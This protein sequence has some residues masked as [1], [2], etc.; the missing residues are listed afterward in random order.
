MGK[1]YSANGYISAILRRS[2]K[3]VLVEGV[4]D[5]AVFHRLMVESHSDFDG[6]NHVDHAGIFDDETMAGLGNKAK[7]AKLL[8]SIN[9]LI[10]HHPRLGEVF[11]SLTDREWDD[12]DISPAGMNGQWA[13]PA[14]PIPHFIT[15]GHSIENYFLD[16][17]AVIAYLK[18]MFSENLTPAYTA[19]IRGSFGAINS[20]A[21]SYSL[22]AKNK[23]CITRCDGLLD[24]LSIDIK[25][26]KYY[27][28]SSLAEKMAARNIDNAHDLVAEINE[29]VDTVWSNTT[30]SEPAK[31][32]LHGHLGGEVI[33]SCVA[34]N[35]REYGVT[36]EVISQ[37]SHGYQRERERF[38]ADWLSK[39]DP[40]LRTPLDSAVAWLRS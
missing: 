20:L 28:N 11:S 40:Q 1:A 19:T 12:L 22:C 14:Q 30:Y 4:S 25:D 31:W 36:E 26:E 16:A 27:F 2:G 5:K 18:F 35:A 39:I 32:L 34:R 24:H 23:G 7:I 8:E 37:I 13:P 29:A 15:I 6:Q 3:T 21:V 33:W 38:L 17:E 10:Q 9:S